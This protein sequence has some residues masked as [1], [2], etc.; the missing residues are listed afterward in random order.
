[1]PWKKANAFDEGSDERELITLLDHP[2]LGVRKALVLFKDLPLKQ[3]SEIALTEEDYR[4]L[5]TAE[6]A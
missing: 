3:R 4:K 2:G 1:M 6:K 5:K